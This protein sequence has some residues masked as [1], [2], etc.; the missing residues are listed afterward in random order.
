MHHVVLPSTLIV[1]T[2]FPNEFAIAFEFIRFK[3][4]LIESFVMPLEFAIF[5]AAFLE[6]AFEVS[7]IRPVLLANTIIQIF[8]PLSLIDYSF[9]MM[10]LSEA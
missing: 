5:L 7:P 4:S 6:M 1:T 9:V 3:V 8:T 2:V 10:K